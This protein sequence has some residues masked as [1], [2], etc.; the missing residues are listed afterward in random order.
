[1]FFFAG[2][3]IEECL[4]FEEKKRPTFKDITRR[5]NETLERCQKKESA[6]GEKKSERGEKEMKNNKL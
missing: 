2:S 6:S 1:M 4:K 3:E 5:L